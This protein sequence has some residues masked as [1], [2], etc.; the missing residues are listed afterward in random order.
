ML[1]LLNAGI[2]GCVG[3]INDDR[4]VGLQPVSRRTGTAA[5]SGDLLP[6]RG[7]RSDGSPRTVG[8]QQPNRLQHHKGADTVVDASTD[9]P[10]VGKLQYTGGQHPG[11]TDSHPALRFSTIR[12][13]D[14]D[15]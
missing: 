1:S 14:V 4:N 10:P 12:G 9:Q 3:D 15:P 6:S 11:I 2:V 5:G 7:N 13:A 8:G